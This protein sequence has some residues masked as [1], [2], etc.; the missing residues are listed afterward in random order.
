MS[1]KPVRTHSPTAFFHSMTRIPIGIA[2]TRIGRS[3][4]TNAMSQSSVV[5]ITAH[6]SE[7]RRPMRFIRS[8][9][10]DGKTRPSF[11][12][13]TPTG[14]VF[15]FLLSKSCTRGKPKSEQSPDPDAVA[16]AEPGFAQRSLL[17]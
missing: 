9:A 16:S 15:G 8:S 12:L 3:V 14:H 6:I 1:N 2:I 11:K 4:A 5:T 10:K 17:D 7:V 13:K